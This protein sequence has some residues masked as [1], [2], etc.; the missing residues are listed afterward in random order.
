MSS[1]CSCLLFKSVILRKLAEN[2]IPI[3]FLHLRVNINSQR[4]FSGL[5]GHNVLLET[6]LYLLFF[7]LQI[8]GKLNP[9]FLC[10]DFAEFYSEWEFP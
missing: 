2:D 6:L 5:T 8:Q 9:V 10:F 1:F 3:F 7:S 4:Y